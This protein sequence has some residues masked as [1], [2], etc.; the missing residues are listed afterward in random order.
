MTVRAAALMMGLKPRTVRKWAKVCGMAR[1]GRDYWLD[2][3]D[4]RYLS[5]LIG[6]AR[7]RV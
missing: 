7:V 4:V 1:H 6:P 5:S 3:A 2:D